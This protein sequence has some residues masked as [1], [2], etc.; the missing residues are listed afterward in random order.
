M[1]P[2]ILAIDQGKLMNFKEI[3]QNLAQSLKNKNLENEAKKF[4][5]LCNFH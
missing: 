2:K 3:A 5:H 1:K 4:V